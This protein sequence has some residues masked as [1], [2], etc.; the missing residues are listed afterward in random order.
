[1]FKYKRR[2]NFYDCDPAGILF[3]GRVYLICHEAYEIM[4]E[5]FNLKDNFWTNKNF[6]VPIIHSEAKYRKPLLAGETALIEISVTILKDSS[7]ELTYLI[8]NDKNEITNNV[9]TVHVFL[10]KSDWKKSKI[11]KDIKEKLKEHLVNYEY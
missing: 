10:N 6:V 11:D 5:S 4:L 2:I 7:F 1:M 9:R 3:Y 8:K